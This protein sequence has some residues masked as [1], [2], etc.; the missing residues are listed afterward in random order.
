MGNNLAEEQQKITRLVL[1]PRSC[2]T[3]GQDK[4]Y[5]FILKVVA[6]TEG[7]KPESD[8]VRCT[9]RKKS[10]G[11]LEWRLGGNPVDAL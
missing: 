7:S 10:L 3:E 2:F 5:D 1:P 6:A 11:C 9:L 8:L 4:E